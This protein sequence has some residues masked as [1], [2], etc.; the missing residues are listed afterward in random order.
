AKPATMHRGTGREPVRVPL[1]CVRP[2]EAAK[3]S[4]MFSPPLC[5]ISRKSRVSAAAG[6]VCPSV[7]LKL[8]IAPGRHGRA[9]LA[10]PGGGVKPDTPLD[11]GGWPQKPGACA[12]VEAGP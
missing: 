11:G 5:A 7:G 3:I 1:N 9:S 10:P 4:K 12:L 2:S 6:V 8:V